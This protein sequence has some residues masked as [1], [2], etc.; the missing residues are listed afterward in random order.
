MDKIKVGILG[1]TGNVGQRFVQLLENHPWFEVVA[2]CASEKSAGKKYKDAVNWNISDTIPKVAAN[3][4]VGLCEP[5]FD[6]PL[7]FSALDS[8]VAGEVEENFAKKG[9]AVV[10]SASNH[11]RDKDVPML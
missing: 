7:V 6:V 3:M 4:E 11:R 10:S 9:Y 8:S 5:M 1:A 2:L